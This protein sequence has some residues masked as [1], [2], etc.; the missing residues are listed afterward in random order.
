MIRIYE[1]RSKQWYDSIRLASQVF[2]C[3][4]VTIKKLVD[5]GERIINGRMRDIRS[6]DIPK[7]DD[8]FKSFIKQ[9]DLK[10]M[11]AN[12]YLSPDKKV[13]LWASKKQEW[14]PWK[15]YDFPN[16]NSA[17][18]TIVNRE[19]FKTPTW[20]QVNKYH[21]RLFPELTLTPINEIENPFFD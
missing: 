3:N 4:E 10:L 12:F 1:A 14:M 21:R 15:T 8:K 6:T 13:Y 7:Q 11:I 18:K 9:N 16:G 20:V 2:G 17:F 5:K 19:G